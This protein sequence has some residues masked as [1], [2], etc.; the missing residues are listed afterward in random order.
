MSEGRPIDLSEV[1]KARDSLEALLIEL[2]GREDAEEA[3]RI[4]SEYRITGSEENGKHILC[5]YP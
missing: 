1:E 4:I 2:R 5:A 3:L